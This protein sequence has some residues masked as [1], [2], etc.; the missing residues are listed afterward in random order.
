[1][2]LI[3]RKA[4]SKG[5]IMNGLEG[6]AITQGGSGREYQD[7][8]TTRDWAKILAAFPLFAGMSKR[9]LRQLAEQA[10][11]AEFTAGDHVVATGDNADSLYVIL[12]GSAK[13]L[14]KPAARPLRAGDYFGE[15]ALIDGASRSATVVAGR[16]LHVM[17][18]PRQSVVWLTQKHPAI[19]LT[20]FR[21]LSTQLRRLET[22]AARPLLS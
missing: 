13:V 4:I 17:R 5:S 11:F 7:R 12:G 8:P 14:G 22:Q 16:E 9:R 1:M 2:P 18:L 15:L 19:T 6:L 21:N 3:S 20:M 10:T